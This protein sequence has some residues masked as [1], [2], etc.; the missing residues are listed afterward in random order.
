MKLTAKIQKG[1]NLASRLHFNQN[2]KGGND[3]PYISHPYSVAWILSNYSNDEDIIVAGLLHDVLEDVKGYH[4]QDLVE[5][6]GEKIA[7]IVKGVSE[8]KNPND[9]DDDSVSWEDRKINYLRILES[10]S[11]DSLLVSA[12]DKIHNLQSMMDAYQ[13]KGED[14]W[15][16]F[17]SPKDKKLWL[18]KEV[19]NL[20][21]I[22]L[23]NPI[24]KE[25]ELV[26]NKAEKILL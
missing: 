12:A 16:N 23:D 18:Y 7:Q 22:K 14:F 21:K 25:L 11:Q 5:D 6:F 8:D 1:I 15:K 9:E 13:E 10:S 2:R 24:V 3:L 4:Y 19:L 26:Y 20:L 17:N